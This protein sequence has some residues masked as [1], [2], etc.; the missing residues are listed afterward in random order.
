MKTI[1]KYGSFLMITLMMASCMF[2]EKDDFDKSSAIRMEE[3]IT[4]YGDIMKSAPNGWL[5]NYYCKDGYAVNF[6]MK[7]DGKNVVVTSDYGSQNYALGDTLSSLYRIIGDQGPVLTFD[8]YNEIFHQFSEPLGSSNLDGLG[9]DYEFIIMSAAADKIQLK[10][11]KTGY[12][13]TMTALPATTIWKD[14][15]QS[16]V[17]MQIN[18]SPRYKMLFNNDSIGVVNQTS[19][20]TWNIMAKDTT[21]SDYIFYTPTGVHLNSSHTFGVYTVQDFTYD[22]TLSGFVSNDNKNIKL[23]PYYPANYIPYNDYIGTWTF[24]YKTD[25]SATDY[26]ITTATFTQKENKK[27]Y[28]VHIPDFDYDVVCNY[29]MMDGSLSL[30]T[31]Y[32]G[33]YKTMY[34]IYLCP[35]DVAGGTLTWADGAGSTALWDGK[36]SPKELVFMDGDI[37]GSFFMYAFKGNPPSSTNTAGWWSKIVTPILIINK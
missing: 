19:A 20:Y 11:K 12:K 16:S 28:S 3:A 14:Y 24:K 33:M 4:Q 8:S 26:T 37:P 36:T 22:N 30:L 25:P 27:S 9:G 15:L 21:L 23:V 32:L 18:I 29:N 2:N 10:G 13:M 7:F 5:F 17:D 31:Q 6:I 35:W 1:L 34:Y